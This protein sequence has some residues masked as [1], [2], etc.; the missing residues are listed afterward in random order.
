MEEGNEEEKGKKVRRKEERKKELSKKPGEA[1]YVGGRQ[2][3]S[4]FFVIGTST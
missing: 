4:T 1:S 3:V 2:C